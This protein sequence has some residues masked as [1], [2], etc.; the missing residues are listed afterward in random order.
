LWAI[1]LSLVITSKTVLPPDAEMVEDFDSEAASDVGSEIADSDVDD[2]DDEQV[3]VSVRTK[4]GE[5]KLQHQENLEL[6]KYFPD[7]FVVGSDLA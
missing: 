5:L 4:T 3:R 7:I 6:D 2:E 1:L